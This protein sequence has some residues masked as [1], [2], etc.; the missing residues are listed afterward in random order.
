[1]SSLP[2]HVRALVAVYFVATLAHFAHNAEF[3]ALY[4]GMPEWLTREKVYTAW[5]CITCVGVTGLIAARFGLAAL[6][7][8][9]LGAYGALGLDALTHY[10]IALCSEHTLAANITI[11]TEA[12]VG[13]L[14]AVA[15]GL[16]VNIHLRRALLRHSAMR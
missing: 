14:L 16:Q 12:S 9:L 5:L 7:A 3:I 8:L 2:R 1:M 13:V 15:A 11:W 4:P 6:G 10:T